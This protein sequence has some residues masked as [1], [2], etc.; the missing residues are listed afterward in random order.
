VPHRTKVTSR[1]SLL[2]CHLT[3]FCI[4]DKSI[5]LSTTKCIRDFCRT[6]VYGIIRRYSH[7]YLS[8]HS[9]GVF[10]EAFRSLCHCHSNN[11]PYYFLSCGRSTFLRVADFSPR[12]PS[13]RWRD[14]Y[15]WESGITGRPL[16]SSGC[17][18]VAGICVSKREMSRM[19]TCRCCICF[20]PEAI[21][22]NGT[23]P[24]ARELFIWSSDVSNHAYGMT[25]A[26]WD[27]VG[28]NFDR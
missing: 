9:S 24:T 27:Q 5:S 22:T 26:N 20:E 19:T 2:R 8:M 6:L 17:S 25:Y 16:A 7:P 13:K 11:W 14:D 12:R 15:Y 4:A 28:S 18:E 21:L 1:N 23:K 10:D 3:Q